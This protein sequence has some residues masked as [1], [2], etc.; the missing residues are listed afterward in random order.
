MVFKIK[1]V[2]EREHLSTKVLCGHWHL[3]EYPLL[4]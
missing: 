1:P 4:G 3:L 2:M